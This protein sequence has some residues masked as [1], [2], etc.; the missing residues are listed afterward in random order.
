MI[1]L[2]ALAL[3]TQDGVVTDQVLERMP[4]QYP[5]LGAAYGVNATCDAVFDVEENG[6]PTN[7][8]VRCN[9]SV[10]EQVPASVAD[11]VAGQFVQ[12]AEAAISRWR[13]AG[14]PGG[15][16]GVITQINFEI[17]EDERPG[18]QPAQI[19]TG[20]GVAECQGTPIT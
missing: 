10:S 2:L 17:A 16:Q 11:Y 15:R 7:V 1:A 20:P 4:P 5:H 19:P 14:V 12:E 13:Y 8:C 3:L 6:T 18:F 9:T